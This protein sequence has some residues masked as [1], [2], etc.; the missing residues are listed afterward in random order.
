VNTCA[1]AGITAP[2]M[3]R[4]RREH[5]GSFS[6]P[7]ILARHDATPQNVTA[8]PASER[9]CSL[10]LNLLGDDAF[11]GLRRLNQLHHKT[12]GT[13]NTTCPAKPFASLRSCVS[14][15]LRRAQAIVVSTAGQL[16][17]CVYTN[18]W[19]RNVGGQRPSAGEE[20][21]VVAHRKLCRMSAATASVPVPSGYARCPTFVWDAQTELATLDVD[22]ICYL[23]WRMSRLDPFYC[24]I[25]QQRR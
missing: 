25:R 13:K 6:C 24:Y 11:G 2:N 21:R 12:G 18:M 1:T 8:L 15:R 20:R 7:L 23:I 10:R 22:R 16:P 17:P 4:T 14:A 5:V 19:H 9:M 3:R